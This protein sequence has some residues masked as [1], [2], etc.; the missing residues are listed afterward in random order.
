MTFPFS[1]NA[2][3]I[4]QPGSPVSLVRKTIESLKKDELLVR[5]DYASINKM[6]PMMANVNRFQLPAPYV[7]GFDF[8]GEVIQ[9]GS[10]G[11]LKVEIKSSGIRVPAVVLPSTLSQRKATCCFGVPCRPRR[12]ALLE[13][14]F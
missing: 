13:L 2:L 6:D 10:E 5:V 7:L 14:L 8:S 11:G 1:F 9:V 12:P 3:A 4:E